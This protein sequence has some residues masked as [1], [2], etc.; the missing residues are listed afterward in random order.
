MGKASAR[1]RLRQNN[2]AP[3]FSGSKGAFGA[4]IWSQIVLL[5]VALMLLAACLGL[6]VLSV[7]PTVHDWSRMRQW[8]PMSAQVE[9]VRLHKGGTARGGTYYAAVVRYHYRAEGTQYTGTRAAVDGSGDS[10]R[11]FHQQLADRL[12]NAQRT[13]TPVQV[14]V[15]P[16]NP[17]ESVVDR[18]LR[19]GPLVLNLVMAGVAGGAGLLILA[20]VRTL[21]CERR[22][23]NQR[24]AAAKNAT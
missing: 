8:Q 23:R 18:S 3:S 22:E 1:K 17:A 7:G 11:S 14:W 9:S 19:V 16:V 10:W 13:G 20:I 6:M 4:G 2:A 15:N 12:H 5:L 21:R 24:Q